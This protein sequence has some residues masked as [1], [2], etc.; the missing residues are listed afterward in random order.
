MQRWVADHFSL[1]DLPLVWLVRRRWLDR[2]TWISIGFPMAWRARRRH[3][4]IYHSQ[5]RYLRYWG[6]SLHLCGM[7]RRRRRC[8]S[9]LP[10]PAPSPSIHNCKARVFEVDTCRIRDTAVSYVF[11]KLSNRRLQTCEFCNKLIRLCKLKVTNLT[12]SLQL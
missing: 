9:P 4:H 5:P 3:A 7:A 12:T 2:T 1:T 6:R 10:L 11:T 8:R